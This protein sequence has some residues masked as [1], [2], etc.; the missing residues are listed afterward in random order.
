MKEAQPEDWATAVEYDERFRAKYEKEGRA[1]YLHRGYTPLKDL[2]LNESQGA[3]DLE[4]EI[5]CA[6]GCGL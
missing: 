3:F 5:Y 6:G 4:D 1:V 2:D